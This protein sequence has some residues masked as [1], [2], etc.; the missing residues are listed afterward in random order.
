MKLKLNNFVLNKFTMNS[1][2]S[3]ASDASFAYGIMDIFATQ[4]KPQLNFA[5]FL[6]TFA[7]KE[8]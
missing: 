1:F 6:S 2:F 4:V 7:S 8:D 5:I 3:F